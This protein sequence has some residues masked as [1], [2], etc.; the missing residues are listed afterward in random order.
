MTWVGIVVAILML[1]GLV[2]SAVP[3]LPGTPLI[4]AGALVYAVATDFT[5]IGIGRLVVLGLLAVA[6]AVLAH[7]AAALGVR[8]AGGSRWAMV[9]A[10][11]GAILGLAAAPAGLLLGPL[12][13]AIVAE[14]VRTHRLATSVRAGI[15]AVV[16]S[17]GRCGGARRAGARHGRAV[18]LVGVAG[19][20]I[21][22]SARGESSA[23]RA[24][25]S[26]A[27]APPGGG[28]QRVA[29]RSALRAGSGSHRHT[30]R[31]TPGAVTVRRG[32]DTGR[33]MQ[34]LAPASIVVATRL[35]TAREKGLRPHRRVLG[36]APR[37]RVRRAPA[38]VEDF[39]ARI[40]VRLTIGAIGTSNR[41]G[42]R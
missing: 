29:A 18:R 38:N 37:G 21:P 27:P 10:L 13:G 15:G 36:T 32:R 12:L 33:A 3:V 1:A 24:K 14:L 41:G 7:V 31:T 25:R 30:S 35:R 39:P 8:G 5:P 26:V 34:Q 20:K 40:G 9:G 22:R 42:V 19:M 6:A 11:V 4:V 2:G 16:G 28:A 17:G 23:P